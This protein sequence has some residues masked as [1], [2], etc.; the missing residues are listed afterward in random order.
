M[1]STLAVRF[2]SI[3]QKLVPAVSIVSR[4]SFRSFRSVVAIWACLKLSIGMCVYIDARRCMISS[5]MISIEMNSTVF[6]CTPPRLQAV[7]DQRVGVVGNGVVIGDI[8]PGRMRHRDALARF[9]A[10][11]RDIDDAQVFGI[12]RR[13]APAL[14]PL[15]RQVERLPPL[16]QDHRDKMMRK[17]GRL[18]RGPY[19]G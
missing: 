1:S 16:R 13:V 12:M 17:V 11:E 19:P 7:E 15:A 4:L 3:T 5:G 14:F 2:P 18:L 9:V 6:F 10:H 8:Q